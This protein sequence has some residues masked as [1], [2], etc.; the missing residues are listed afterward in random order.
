[1]HAIIIANG[2]IPDLQLPLPPH[3]L[4]IAAD[5]GVAHAL[6]FGLAPDILIGD[7]DSIDAGDTER[8]ERAG[9]QVIRHPADKEETDLELALDH[10][11]E[12]GA[13]RIT[14]YGLLGGR[15][16]MTFSNI[17][18]LASPKY[19]GVRLEAAAGGTRIHVLRGGETLELAGRTGDQVSVLSLAGPAL[20]LTYEGLAW[21]LADADLPFGS[22]KGMSNRMDQDRAAISLRVGVVLV[23]TRSTAGRI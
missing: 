13:K 1:M 9:G 21:P 12:Y 19:A 16:D 14:C 5:G 3:D 7:L 22:P 2:D 17:L 4:L 15:W 20:G 23:A 11:I 6:R 8:I 10:A 18:L